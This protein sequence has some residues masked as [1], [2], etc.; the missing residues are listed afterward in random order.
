MDKT[1][2]PDLEAPQIKPEDILKE[3]MEYVNSDVNLI[4]ALTFYADKHKIEVEVLAA[5]IKKS[6]I[7]KSKLYEVAENIR[8]VEKVDRLPI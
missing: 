6:S 5:I 7:I 1:L 8:L 4:E 2:F 3:V